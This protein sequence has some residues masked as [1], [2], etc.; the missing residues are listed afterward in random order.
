MYSLHPAAGLQDIQGSEE[1]AEPHQKIQSA[2]F[3]YITLPVFSN[4]NCKEMAMEEKFVDIKCELKYI[5][6]FEMSNYSI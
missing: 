5:R 6:F 3:S 4:I 1:S 2:K